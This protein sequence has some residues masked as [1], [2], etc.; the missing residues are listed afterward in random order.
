M[1]VADSYLRSYAN[2][3]CGSI[4]H[5]ELMSVQRYREHL[6]PNILRA[7]IQH[8]HRRSTR[9]ATRQKELRGRTVRQK[10]SYRDN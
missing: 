2:G 6:Q 3:E 5:P 7:E 1:K 9:L 4:D 8:T 10:T